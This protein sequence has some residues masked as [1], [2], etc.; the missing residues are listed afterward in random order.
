MFLNYDCNLIRI[1][2][3]ISEHRRNVGVEFT[4]PGRSWRFIYTAIVKQPSGKN[5]ISDTRNQRSGFNQKC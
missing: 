2:A 3:H 4:L 5:P 1:V